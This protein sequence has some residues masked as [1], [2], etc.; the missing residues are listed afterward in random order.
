MSET[1]YTRDELVAPE[2]LSRIVG[3]AIPDCAQRTA[4]MDKFCPG[5]FGQYEFAVNDDEFVICIRVNRPNN[6]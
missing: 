4:A 6:G 3:E 5:V 1:E 2:E